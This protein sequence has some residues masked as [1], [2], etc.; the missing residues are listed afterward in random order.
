MKFIFVAT[1][2]SQRQYAYLVPLAR[3]RVRDYLISYYH[4]NC[5]E[6]FKD[7]GIEEFTNHKAVAKKGAELEKRS[8]DTTRRKKRNSHDTEGRGFRDVR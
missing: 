2:A 8:T 4:L 1:G 7:F 3:Q 6:E 5:I